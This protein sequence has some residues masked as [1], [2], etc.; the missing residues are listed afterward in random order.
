MKWNW[1][2]H[3]WKSSTRLLLGIATIW[4]VVYVVLF[5]STVFSGAM[6][7]FN[8]EDSTPRRGTFIDLIQLEKKIQAGEIKELR[9]SSSD[10]EAVD[11]S[12]SI[13][14]THVTNKSTREELIGQA[15]APGA[16]GLPRVSKIDEN[17]A[18]PEENFALP[19]AFFVLMGFHLMTMLLVFLM[20]PV[21]IILP[22]KNERLDQNMRIVW[23]ILACTIGVF[24]DVVYWYLHVWRTPPAGP[25]VAPEFT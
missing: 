17:A 21:Y 22:L 4:P 3:A 14:Y 6:I 10:F 25:P 5:V 24:S 13:F 20:M 15:R 1:D 2:P 7:V 12:G 18:R 19:F 8:A 23:V 16:D 11:R 9:I